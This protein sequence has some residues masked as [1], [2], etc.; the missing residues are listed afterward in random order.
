MT[1]SESDAMAGTAAE[2]DTTP[3]PGPS[4]PP[5]EPRPEEPPG[6]SGAFDAC[7]EDIRKRLGSDIPFLFPRLEDLTRRRLGL[8][9]LSSGALALA[10]LMGVGIR[11]GLALLVTALV[12]QWADIPWGRWAAI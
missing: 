2:A 8:A 9:P 5:F 4:R 6:R 7:V 11:L 10:G 3:E 1:D 12:G